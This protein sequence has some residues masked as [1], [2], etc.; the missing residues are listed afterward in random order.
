MLAK[1]IAYLFGETTVD[2]I[3][4]ELGTVLDALR[5]HQENSKVKAE[6]ARLEQLKHQLQVE[7]SGRVAEK[8]EG[9]LR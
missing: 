3:I 4:A 6:A 8:L 5:A 9:L 7:H 2:H 1:L